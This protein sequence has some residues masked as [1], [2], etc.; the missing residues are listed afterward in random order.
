MSVG[1]GKRPDGYVIALS[2]N[3]LSQNS[4]TGIPRSLVA[5]A[6]LDANNFPQAIET[7][8]NPERASSYNN[9]IADTHQ[10]LCIEASATDYRIIY[11]DEKGH[12]A[13][14]NNF[15]HPEMKVY[16]TQPNHIGSLARHKRANELLDAVNP[17]QPIEPEIKKILT[18]HGPTKKSSKLTPC[19]HDG[20]LHTIFSTIINMRKGIIMVTSG[21]PCSHDFHTIWQYG[22]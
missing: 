5:L 20:D 18:D 16:D 14:A 8:L 15:L 4:K 6:I 2:G 21:P 7:A 10:V 9:I 12:F 1:V 3:E 17:D 13:H 11:P 22:S 19:R